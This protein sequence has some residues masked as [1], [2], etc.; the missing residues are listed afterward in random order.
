[1]QNFLE[2]RLVGEMS[3]A[4]GS[5]HPE[6]SHFSRGINLC[7]PF[8][9]KFSPVDSTVLTRFFPGLPVPPAIRVVFS[10]GND[11]EVGPPIVESVP[12]DMIDNT[13]K[14]GEADGDV[15]Q[16]HSVLYPV[17]AY[18]S[19]SVPTPIIALGRPFQVPDDVEHVVINDGE[20]TL[21]KRNL[22]HAN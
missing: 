6:I 18:H 1:M 2:S 12:V 19:E 14:E 21:S 13:F 17:N 7:P 16:G 5:E 15:V 22:F 11:T 8:P 3:G 9:V 10:D 20:L 4:F